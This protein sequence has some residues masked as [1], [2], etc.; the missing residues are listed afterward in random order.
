MSGMYADHDPYEPPTRAVRAVI[1]HKQRVTWAMFIRY[2]VGIAGV[3]LAGVTLA[4]FLMWKGSAETQISQLR[5]EMSAAQQAQAQAAG[6]MSG[7]S[8]RVHGISGTVNSIADLLSPF[9]STCQ[10]DLNGSNGQPAAFLFMC[11]PA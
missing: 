11:K 7:L 10:T 5:Q 3:A 9:S 4:M 2:V 1:H 6:D 8:D